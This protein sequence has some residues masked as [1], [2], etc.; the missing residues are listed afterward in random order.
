MNAMSDDSPKPTKAWEL[1]DQATLES[2]L[3]SELASDPSTF[4][5]DKLCQDSLGFYLFCKFCKQQGQA[6]AGREGGCTSTS[7]SARACF[8]EEVVRYRR[9]IGERGKAVKALSILRRF[10]LSPAAVAQRT[11]QG[12]VACVEEGGGEGGG[13]GE[14]KVDGN[15]GDLYRV[16]NVSLGEEELLACYEEALTEGEVASPSLPS[17]PSASPP[18]TTTTTT[19]KVMREGGDEGGFAGSSPKSS[20]SSS[21]RQRGRGR[22]RSR[23]DMTSSSTASTKSTSGGSSSSSGSGGAGGIPHLGPEGGREAGKERGMSPLLVSNPHLNALGMGGKVKKEV[24]EIILRV[25][26]I[27]L[28]VAEPLLQEVVAAE[29]KGQQQEQQQQQPQ[30]AG[31]GG[32]GGGGGGR[33]KQETTGWALSWRGGKSPHQRTGTGG[34]EERERTPHPLKVGIPNILTAAGGGG[35]RGGGG[36]AGGGG[37]GGGGGNKGRVSPLSKGSVM[38]GEDASGSV[39]GGEG[40]REGGAMTTVNTAGTLMAPDTPIVIPMPPGIAASLSSS[41][42]SVFGSGSEE[43]EGGGI[44]T[45]TTTTAT[46]TTTTTQQQKTAGGAGGAAMRD[47]VA[48]A[49]AASLAA[50][51]SLA[52]ASPTPSAACSP[53]LSDE[54]EEE[55]QQQRQQQQQ[56][57]QQQQSSSQQQQQQQQQT[58]KKEENHLSASLFD[59]LEL[60]VWTYLSTH[61][62]P[63]FLA[64]PLFHKYTQFAYLSKVRSLP[65]LPPSL[66]PSAHLVCHMA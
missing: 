27:I 64:S 26:E 18:P 6:E 63:S 9:T 11:G 23:V 17:L 21:S 14:E 55:E 58:K 52:L 25:A 19:W 50:P 35:G 3:S 61:F 22:S 54:D 56:H 38:K 37:G 47:A 31:G 59:K 34:E 12:L 36:G 20:S 53:W 42:S 32:G 41:S 65:S 4:S 39:S 8:L 29:A 5:L 13:E 45:A 10:L 57:Q 28:R 15:E 46:S 2:F 40:G 24:C 43:K 44:T 49:A 60:L 1:P 16:P 62:G 48:A 30:S 7:T 33:T 51:A 66:P